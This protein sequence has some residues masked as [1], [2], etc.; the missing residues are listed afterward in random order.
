MFY[1]ILMFR[2]VSVFDFRGRCFMTV[3]DPVNDFEFPEEWLQKAALPRDV[4]EERIRKGR[5]LVLSDGTVLTRGYTTGTTAAAA[6]KAAVLSFFR[7]PGSCITVPTPAGPIAEMKI[8]SAAHGLAFVRK[9]MNDHES[10]I[11][12]GK[13][14]GALAFDG[15]AAEKLSAG[16]GDLPEKLSGQLP[17]SPGVLLSYVLPGELSDRAPSLA[18]DIFPSGIK[19]DPSGSSPAPEGGQDLRTILVP[20]RCVADV[21]ADTAVT[22]KSDGLQGGRGG[23]R[24][25]VFAGKGIG[26][27]RKSGFETPV[28][29]PAVNPRPRQ[30]IR[31]GIIEALSE[32]GRQVSGSPGPGPQ[33]SGSPGPGQQ[34]SG[35]PDSGEIN[36][37][38]FIPEGEEL[39]RMTLNEKIGIVGGISVLGTTGFVEP[40]NDHLGEMKDD[41]IR[42]SRK[43][44]LTTGR[45]GMAYATMLFPDH[46]VVLVGSRISEGISA[47]SS[48]EEIVVCGL[49]GLVLKWGNPDMMKDS[50]FAT[51]VEMLDRDPGNRAI[52]KAFEMAVR[53]GR[54]ARIVVIDRT[55]KVLLDS[56]ENRSSV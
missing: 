41:I 26:I 15:G 27:I 34:V 38:L 4:L 1:F 10:D 25:R 36:V 9:V 42:S 7:E 46:D 31:D 8:E 24:V 52:A 43:I 51:V 50:G 6:V 48:A 32:I 39:S 29:E 5:A 23:V 21:M 53:K 28:G 2:N 30:Q 20:E 12:R 17:E 49:P 14:F 47:A 19:A 37:I 13:L 55:G 16:P 45:Q 11:T 33:V 22:G 40:W 35:F 3:K 54:G 56:A 44:V 18:R